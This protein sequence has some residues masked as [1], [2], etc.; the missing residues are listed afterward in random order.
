VIGRE[1]ELDALSSAATDA[2]A[3]RG[4]VVFLAGPTGSGKS[5]LLRAAAERIDESATETEF[6]RTACLRSGVGVPLGAC[7]RL[8]A[9]LGDEETR[10]ERGR[11]ILALIGQVAPPLLSFLPGIGPIAGTAVKA[12]TDISASALGDHKEKQGSFADD[13][14]ATFRLIAADRPLV[15][16]IDE[17]HWIDEPSAEVV[18]T[19]AEDLDQHAIA[20]VLSYDPEAVGD[21]HPLTLLRSAIGGATC[22]RDLQLQELDAAAV[23][24]LLVARYGELPAPRL[25]A[26]LHDKT[27]GNLRFLE[28]YLLTLEEQGVLREVDGHWALDGSIE[29][30]PESWRLRGRL[31]T[32]QAPDNLLETLKPRFGLLSDEEKELLKRGAFQGPRFLSLVLARTLGVDESEVS[33][34]LEPI[35]ERRLITFE[36]VDDWWGDRSDLVAFDPTVLQELVYSRAAVSPRKRRE[37]HR[38]VAEAFE[39][40]VADVRPRPRQALLEIARHYEEAR[41]PVRAATLLVEV[42]ESTFAQG[43]DRQTAL[44]ARS[45]LDLLA[46]EGVRDGSPQTERLFARAALLLLLGGE[47]SWRAATVSSERLFALA[48]EAE[49]AA[50]ACGDGQLRAGARLAAAQLTLAYGGRLETAVDAYA[51]V[52]EVARDAGDAVTEFAA[53]LKLGHHRGSLDLHDG[54]AALEEAS[55]LLASGRVAERLDADALTLEQG[56]LDSALGVAKF[57]LGVYGE[58]GRLLDSAVQILSATRLDDDYGWALCFRGQLQTSL[59]LWDEAEESLRAAIAVF[60]EEQHSL[61]ARGYFRALLGRV[62]VEREPQQLDVAR[63]ELEAGRRETQEAGYGSLQPLMDAYWAELLIAEGLEAGRREA[64]ELLAASPSHGWKRGD[65]LRNSLRARIALLDS[66]HE[67][68]LACSGAAYDLLVEGRGAVTAVRSEEIVYVRAQALAAA[69]LPE[70]EERFAEAATILRAKADSLT[71]PAQRDSLLQRVRLSRE[72]LAAAP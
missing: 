23:D 68:A 25:G 55:E 1:R 7:Y 11:R 15:V 14:V 52:V 12:A 36:D 10:G 70:A 61:G 6:V 39:G 30:D 5:E 66:R 41:E 17:A 56:H 29:G 54:A 50:E 51:E 2:A 4:C 45:A 18:A 34:R 8:L 44:H 64:E 57:D 9:A 33:S 32:V 19:L 28:Q 62:G 22:T 37:G 69:S 65:V 26:W 63:R 35:Q 38:Q 53:L 21:T 42:A 27:R 67:D 60:E 20:I 40:L 47:A 71:D 43:A 59:G 3:G 72:I 46:G 58:A 13:V 49:Q 16:V 24:A 48:A 31:E